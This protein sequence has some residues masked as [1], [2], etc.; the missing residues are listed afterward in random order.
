MQNQTSIQS[1]NLLELHC[2]SGLHNYLVSH[3]NFCNTSIASDLEDTYSQSYNTAKLNDLSNKL[4]LDALN[5]YIEMYQHGFGSDSQFK[6]LL[7][8]L[9]TNSNY[10]NLAVISDDLSKSVCDVYDRHLQY[11]DGFFNVGEYLNSDF[12]DFTAD[13]SPKDTD[14]FQGL[15]L[16]DFSLCVAELKVKSLSNPY[17]IAVMKIA[18]LILDRFNCEAISIQN[19][20]NDDEY[21]EIITGESIGIMNNLLSNC[22]YREVVK[23]FSSH[24]LDDIYSLTDREI[25]EALYNS[26]INKKDSDETLVDYEVQINEHLSQV[27]DYFGEDSGILNSSIATIKYIEFISDNSKLAHNYMLFQDNLD[28]IVSLLPPPRTNKEKAI[29]SFFKN[30]TKLVNESH[31]CEAERIY[32]QTDEAHAALCNVLSYDVDNFIL[33]DLYTEFGSNIECSGCDYMSFVDSVKDIDPLLQTNSLAR[34]SL[35]ALLKA[36]EVEE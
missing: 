7:N 1:C 12:M 32:V 34:V 6:S 17:R 35:L 27:E 22:Q 25:I 3:Q 24:N 13:L 30:L 20:C 33:E 29:S 19:Q 31:V 36:T 10:V 8:E 23:V 14:T 16:K 15:R 5:F 2:F 9:A 4:R 18:N 28:E 26:E 11:F 21:M